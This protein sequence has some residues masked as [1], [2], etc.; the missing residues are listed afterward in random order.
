MVLTRIN[1]DPCGEQHQQKVYT[2]LKLYQTENNSLWKTYHE[3]FTSFSFSRYQLVL[4]I[5]V[6]NYVLH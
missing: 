3:M 4:T 2:K 6:F 1:F 5:D